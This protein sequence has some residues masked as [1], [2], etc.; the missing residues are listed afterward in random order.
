MGDALLAT[1]DGRVSQSGACV[2]AIDVMQMEQ[3]YCP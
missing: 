3:L 1:V 2:N